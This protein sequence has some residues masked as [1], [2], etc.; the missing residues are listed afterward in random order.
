MKLKIAASILSSDFGELNKE[1]KSVEP[2]VDIIHVDIMDGHFVPNLTFGLPILKDI[3]T[4]KPIE[5]HL[6]VE[7]PDNYLE[8]YAKAGAKRLIVHHEACPHL[9]RT[10]QHIKSLGCLAAVALNPATPLPVLEDI[11]EDIDMVLLMTVNPGFSNQDFISAVLPKVMHLR[12]LMPD[13]DIEVDGGINAKTGRLCRDAG[14]NILVSA[15]YI[16]DA[17]DRKKAIMSLRK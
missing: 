10:V 13:L 9:H 17:K 7:N 6:M 3:K 8:D 12:E 14:A 11:I 16:F 2:Y 1:I 5:C 4:K 15:S